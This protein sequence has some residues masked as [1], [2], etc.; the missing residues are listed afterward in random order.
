MCMCVCVCV[1]AS[2]G[3]V[4]CGLPCVAL[5]NEIAI[6]KSPKR[7]LRTET[8]AATANDKKTPRNCSLKRTRWEMGGHCERCHVT[9][10]NHLPKE[11]VDAKARDAN[12]WRQGKGLDYMGDGSLECNHKTHT[13]QQHATQQQHW[14]AAWYD[15]TCRVT[16][17]HQTRPFRVLQVPT[18]IPPLAG[19]TQVRPW[20]YSAVAAC[21]V[22][23]R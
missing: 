1:V 14:A 16:N 13:L 9:G 18:S 21:Y 4:T 7:P 17:S 6:M 10:S 19:R 11:N 3:F 8:A 12:L 2:A 23:L 20:I 5:H 22:W 15:R